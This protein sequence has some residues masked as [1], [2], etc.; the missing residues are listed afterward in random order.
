[1]L[2]PAIVYDREPFPF[3]T[4]PHNQLPKFHLVSVPNDMFAKF[5]T[6]IFLHAFPIFS[7]H[8]NLYVEFI[9]LPQ[10]YRISY[11]N[12]EDII[13]VRSVEL[14][15][16]LWSWRE[17][18][19]VQVFLCLHVPGAVHR[20]PRQATGGAPGSVPE[21]LSRGTHGNRKFSLSSVNPNVILILPPLSIAR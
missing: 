14:W 6:T 12:R 11:I 19:L 2:K 8:A 20:L 10:Q 9:F 7:I 3:T 4:Y 17:H 21:R 5:F 15:C 18:F 1:M 16:G 13:K